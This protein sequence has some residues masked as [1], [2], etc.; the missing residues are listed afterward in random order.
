MF[1]DKISPQIKVNE[2]R[3]KD[4]QKT[5]KI[6]W[7]TIGVST[8]AILLFA[9]LFINSQIQ[10]NKLKKNPSQ[11]TNTSSNNSQDESKQLVEVVGKLVILPKDETPTIATVSDLTKL[12]G[13]EFFNNA[14]VGDKVLIYSKAQK[15]ILFRP[16]DNKIIELAPLTGGTENTPN[17]QTSPTK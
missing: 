2:L 5:I 13:Q 1:E 14:K 8:V 17:T 16:S 10:I 3:N 11:Q 7:I 9:G 15:A 6:M 12:K 4:S